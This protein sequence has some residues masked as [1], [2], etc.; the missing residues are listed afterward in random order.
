[1]LLAYKQ[2]E[3]ELIEVFS[4]FNPDDLDRNW[5]KSSEKF[6]EKLA[7]ILEERLAYIEPALANLEASVRPSPGDRSVRTS[8]HARPAAWPSGPRSGTSLPA[9]PP[10]PNA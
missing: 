6:Q 4:G 3:K 2:S 7:D 5:P 1:M 9:S 8:P 10:R